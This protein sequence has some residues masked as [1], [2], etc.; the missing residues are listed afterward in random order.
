MANRKG[1]FVNT[2]YGT[3]EAR[4]DLSSSTFARYFDLCGPKP[5]TEGW[6]EIPWIGTLWEARQK[7]A[8]ELKP[9]FL[10][11]MNGHPFG[12]V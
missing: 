2:L 10:W 4:N 1:D 3:F 8:A 6:A 11:A 7:A 12:C 9:L 5:Q